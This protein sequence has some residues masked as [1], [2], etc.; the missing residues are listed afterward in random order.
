MI[1][2]NLNELL[3]RQK[4]HRNSDIHDLLTQQCCAHAVKSE[5][6]AE[7]IENKLFWREEEGRAKT[8]L[9]PQPEQ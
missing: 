9:P 5:Q 8:F 7:L 3:Q 1:F 2:L 4:E 6:F